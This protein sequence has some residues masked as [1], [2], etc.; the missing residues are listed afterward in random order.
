MS[1]KVVL[2]QE[3]FD[4]KFRTFVTQLPDPETASNYM[5]PFSLD[6]FQKMQGWRENERKKIQYKISTICRKEKTAPM[7]RDEYR[8]NFVT[9]ARELAQE[10]KG[11]SNACNLD[12]DAINDAFTCIFNQYLKQAKVDE[13]GMTEN[14]KTLFAKIWQESEEHLIVKLKTF[15]PKSNAALDSDIEK[16]LQFVRRTDSDGALYDIFFNPTKH[17]KYRK[18]YYTSYFVSTEVSHLARNQLKLIIFMMKEE[19]QKCWEGNASYFNCTA[20][21]A[22]ILEEVHISITNVDLHGWKFTNVFIKY[23]LIRSFG[24]LVKKMEVLERE[25]LMKYSLV[26]L[27]ESERQMFI[28]EFKKECQTANDDV[29]A[30]KR[31]VDDTLSSILVSQIKVSVGSQIFDAILTTEKFNQKSSMMHFLLKE[32]LDTP[33]EIFIS[34][35]ENYK[36]FMEKWFLTSLIDFCNNDQFLLRSIKQ[37]M[38]A[39]IADLKTILRSFATIAELKTILRSFEEKKLSKIKGKNAWWINLKWLLEQNGFIFQVEYVL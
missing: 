9:K 4:N 11:G 12:Q 14:I 36:R 8:K 34:Y 20:S 39:T 29:L 19:I 21:I 38:L 16:C 31:F 13:I 27:L 30:A 3:D 22:Q 28:E 6:L 25:N 18:Y 17:L 10:L 32:L 33:F 23:F 2:W 37:K 26:A 35:I 1:P 5:S 24:I 7:K 15:Q